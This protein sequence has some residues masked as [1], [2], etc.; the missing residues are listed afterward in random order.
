MES[1]FDL[2]PGEFYE[3]NPGSSTRNTEANGSTSNLSSPPYPRILA[4]LE[5][6][7]SFEPRSDRDGRGAALDLRDGMV[8][9]PQGFATVEEAYAKLRELDA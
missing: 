3:A 6:L 1:A 9:R 8:V 5:G 4:P 7:V 2:F